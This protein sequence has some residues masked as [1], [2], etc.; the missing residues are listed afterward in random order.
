MDAYENESLPDDQ[1]LDKRTDREKDCLVDNF[2]GWISKLC[3]KRVGLLVKSTI[4]TS[5][6][7]NIVFDKRTRP[8]ATY[9]LKTV[10][11]LR[12]KNIKINMWRQN[13][14]LVTSY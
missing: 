11:V 1:E 5:H 7:K 6:M 2:I 13:F 10:M 4:T 3:I 12:F 14:S 9:H 8:K